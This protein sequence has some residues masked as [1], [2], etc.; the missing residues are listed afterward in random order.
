MRVQDRGVLGAEKIER[1]S[2]LEGKMKRLIKVS[3]E[4]FRRIR[5]GGPSKSGRSFSVDSS[6]ESSVDQWLR[7]NDF[8]VEEK[9]KHQEGKV[10]YQVDVTNESEDRLRELNK[11]VIS[12]ETPFTYDDTEDSTDL[13]NAEGYYLLTGLFR[14]VDVEMQKWLK[15]V[16][17]ESGARPR[18]V[19]QT[20]QVWNVLAQKV[21]DVFES[22][23]GTEEG[24][25]VKLP[26]V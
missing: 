15:Q 25:N 12:V 19:Q 17:E 6:Q 22:L 4:E 10:T 3:S 1:G 16:K 14:K 20:E 8:V 11:F 26:T 24:S 18:R 23:S 21:Q 13:S 9:F 7:D 2:R 5:Q